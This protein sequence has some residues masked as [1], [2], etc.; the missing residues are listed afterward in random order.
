MSS[1]KH[2]IRDYEE[3]VGDVFVIPRG[4]LVGAELRIQPFALSANRPKD[5]TLQLLLEVRARPDAEFETV[6]ASPVLSQ[7]TEAYVPVTVPLRE[8]VVPD[9]QGQTPGIATE[10]EPVGRFRLIHTGMQQPRYELLL[11]G[12]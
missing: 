7:Y 3:L 11:I 1:I 12:L 2:L 9:G 5:D 10:P 4:R 6:A 8:A